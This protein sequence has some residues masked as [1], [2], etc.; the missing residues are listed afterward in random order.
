MRDHTTTAT[1]VDMTRHRRPAY[2]I[3]TLA[4]AAL[5]LAGCSGDSSANG[6][7]GTSFDPSAS[8]SETTP[9]D[10]QVFAAAEASAKKDVAM[11]TG[12]EVPEDATWAT[13]TYRSDRAKAAAEVKKQGLT[14]KGET[15]WRGA[16]P[17]A[18]DPDAIGGWQVAMHVCSESTLRIYKGGK[19]VT[20]G[21]DG[22]PLPKGKRQVAYL[23]SF[24]TP[25]EGKTWQVDSRQQEE[26]ETC[27]L[28]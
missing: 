15:T 3:T 16:R 13:N 6:T 11:P 20:A 18:S 5:A 12:T 14:F 21:K 27:G 2:L 8:Q 25:D 9:T 19:D 26:G 17:E 1:L 7:D 4:A 23:Y 24:T 22:K 28:K 10:E